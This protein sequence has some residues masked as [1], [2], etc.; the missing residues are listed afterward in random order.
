MPDM[1]TTLIQ[2]ADLAAHLDDP[3]FVIVDVRHDLAQPASWGESQY[4]AAHIP[5]AR[6][7]H[8][9]RDLSAPKTGRNGRHPLPTP[10][11]CAALFGRLGIDGS[12][13]VVAYD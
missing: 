10:E 8:M 13:Q 3:S 4:L 1:Y 9:D 5:G 2:T 12:K 6:F 11:V 7:A